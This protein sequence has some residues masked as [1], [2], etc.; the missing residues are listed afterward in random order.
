M[1][2]IFHYVDSISRFRIN[3][4]RKLLFE[5]AATFCCQFSLS[6]S[7]FFF[8]Y[9][10][11]NGDRIIG[12]RCN[13][14]QWQPMFSEREK[15]RESGEKWDGCATSDRNVCPRQISFRRI[16]FSAKVA[17]S[18]LNFHPRPVHSPNIAYI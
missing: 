11:I 9:T 16:L 17:N 3:K 14:K 7:P 6:L 4:I 1:S 5:V 2:S 10:S 13:S 15:E 18:E 12:D 8:L